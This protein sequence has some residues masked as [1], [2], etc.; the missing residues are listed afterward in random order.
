[1]F[2]FI[3][4]RTCELIFSACAA[5]INGFCVVFL[6]FK[7]LFIMSVFVVFVSFCMNLVFMD[8]CMMKC[9]VY[10]YV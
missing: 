2:L 10:M 3:A 1:M 9:C 8:V 7:L 4:S 5:L 6:F